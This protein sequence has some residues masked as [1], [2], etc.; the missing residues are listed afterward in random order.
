MNARSLSSTQHPSPWLSVARSAIVLV[1]LLALAGCKQKAELDTAY[2]KTGGTPGLRSVNG[3]SVLAEM[4]ERE[5]ATVTTIQRFSPRLE[6]ADIIVWAPD[7]PDPPSAKHREYLE[8]WL[9]EGS[10]R[11][12]IYIGRDY[13]AT[14]DYWRQALPHARPE[15]AAEYQRKLAE[16]ISLQTFHRKHPPEDQTTPWFD[17]EARPYRTVTKQEG[18]WSAGIDPAKMKLELGVRY[19]VP[20]K[21]EGITY[22]GYDYVHEVLLSSNQ[23]P[24]VMQVVSPDWYDGRLLIVTNG[25]FLL[26]LPLINKE[27]RKLAGRLIEATQPEGRRVAFVES[28]KGGPPI[29]HREERPQP[30]TGFEM[31]TIWPLNV[32]LLHVLFWL[33][34]ACVCLYPVFGRPRKLYDA[35][36]RQVMVATT[37]LASLLL[38]Y[39]P[40]NLQDESPTTSGDFG[41]HLSALG[42]M[43]S[44]TGDHEYAT[45][46]LQHY[47][48]HVK[49]DSGAPHAPA[50]PPTSQTKSLL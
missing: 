13:D 26:N 42:E 32:V 31:L 3:T 12:V 22:Y 44:L 20:E 34:L 46:K 21:T 45:A 11:T 49:C 47:L 43:L 5:G 50:K 28:E 29:R 37:P 23:E 7:D 16:A 8:D 14:V 18:P 9:A 36:V 35:V 24:L 15:Q 6:R 4:F 27:N 40:E 19:S 10:G 2:G 1:T 25:S 38:S 17:T 30:R 39:R 41:K 48:D 33:L